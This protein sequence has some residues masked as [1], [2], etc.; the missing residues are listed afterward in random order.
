MIQ[1]VLF[2]YDSESFIL[3]ISCIDLAILVEITWLLV[4]FR[5]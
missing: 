2:Y 1:K 3:M 4:V 5:H